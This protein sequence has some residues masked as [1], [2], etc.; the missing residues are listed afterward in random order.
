ML[1]LD[2]LLGYQLHMTLLLYSDS[3]HVRMMLCLTLME[4]MV[5]FRRDKGHRARP[6]GECAQGCFFRMV[7]AR[8]KLVTQFIPYCAS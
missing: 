6:E 4:Y 2:T 3:V 5:Y 1:H 7:N 8:A